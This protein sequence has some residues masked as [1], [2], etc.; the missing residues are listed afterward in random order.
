MATEL[1]LLEDVNKLGRSGDLVSVKPGFA[2]NFLIPKK[3]AVFAD[4]NTIKMQV[5][6]QEERAKQA[7]VDRAESETQ[8]SHIEG[9]TPSITVKVDPEGHMYGSVTAAEVV[10][11]LAESG[12]EVEKRAVNLKHPIKSIGAHAIEL[13]LKEG[14]KAILRLK[15]LAEGAPEIAEEEPVAEEA[16][17][18]EAAPVEEVASEESE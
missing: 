16:S 11:L 2:R 6:L 1:L 3:K 10:N 17:V 12:I 9:V 4:A 13:K 15:V 14:V 7:A 8:A 5:R 18:E